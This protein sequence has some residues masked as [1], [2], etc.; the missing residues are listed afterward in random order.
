V[1]SK[2]KRKELRQALVWQDCIKLTKVSCCTSF[3]ATKKPFLIEEILPKALDSIKSK[4][5]KMQQ[6]KI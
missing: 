4:Y 3:T 2:K 1:I 5:K 6:N